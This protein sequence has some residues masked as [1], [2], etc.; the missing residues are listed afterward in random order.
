MATNSFYVP[1]SLA[2]SYVEQKRDTA[3]TK[4]YAGAEQEIGIQKQAAL[5]S[6]GEQYDQAINNAYTSYLASQRGIAASAMGQGYKEA[7][8]QKA[9]EA[10][11]EN[12]RQANLSA[13][14]AR[15]Q[16][17]TSA[18]EQQSALQERYKT[19]VANL[20]KAAASMNDYLE[21]V[22][23]LYQVD[24][25][26]NAV[27]D[28][29]KN[30]IGY[31]NADQLGLTA[32]S[33]YDVLLDAQ[34]QNYYDTTGKQAKAYTEWLRDKYGAGSKEDQA[35]LQYMY[36]GG[37][38][39]FKRAAYQSAIDRRNQAE[40]TKQTVEE[41]RQASIPNYKQYIDLD[42]SENIKTNYNMYG[43]LTNI[44]VD[45]TKYAV[46]A[47]NNKSIYDAVLDNFYS[48]NPENALTG[49]HDDNAI[50]NEVDKIN[51]Q[52]KQYD[53]KQMKVGDVI[54]I[55]GIKFINT[56]NGIKVL[57]ETV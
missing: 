37:L 42:D 47:N 12:L 29:E 7:Y 28:E 51:E 15:S 38:S 36:G 52:L 45:G 2:G 3:G 56:K 32:E 33:L 6:L 48:K 31:L 44:E 23:G 43:E 34:P 10:F 53:S 8:E 30:N 50:Y 35:W 20:D 24:A 22:R 14:E 21:Y 55:N 18:A 40:Q 13:S 54:E 26:G 49:V 11:Q 46:M 16:I 17:E 57:K 1:G 27:L 39:D 5:Q 19:E 9:Q 25:Q 4:L 41:N